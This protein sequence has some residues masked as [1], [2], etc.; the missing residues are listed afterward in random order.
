MGLNPTKSHFI[1]YFSKIQG[2]T[3]IVIIALIHLFITYLPLVIMIRFCNNWSKHV[4]KKLSITLDLIASLFSSFCWLL[5]SPLHSTTFWLVH[6]ESS[7]RSSHLL[8]SLSPPDPGVTNFPY[9]FWM[10]CHYLIQTS[11]AIW[12]L[13]L[14]EQVATVSRAAFIQLHLICH[15]HSFLDQVALPMVTH[16][17]ITSQL[18]YCNTFHMGL[19]L[20]IIWKHQ[21]VQNIAMQGVMD[22][23][24]YANVD[25]YSTS[26]TGFQ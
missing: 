12:G 13:L 2:Q 8:I 3:Y 18:V 25:H 17:L 16:T 20:K 4:Y 23:S 5:L 15:L 11:C 10:G 6:W 24:H 21:W 19:L 7:N 26:L 22:I 1:T 14:D 9:L